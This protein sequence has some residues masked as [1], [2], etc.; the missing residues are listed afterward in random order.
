MSVCVEAPASLKVLGATVVPTL[1]GQCHRFAPISPGA[2]ESVLF[3]V[4]ARKKAKGEFSLTFTGWQ[5]LEYSTSVRN[6]SEVLTLTVKP[7]RRAR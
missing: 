4:R 2:T 5:A 1:P 7:K 3:S 6:G